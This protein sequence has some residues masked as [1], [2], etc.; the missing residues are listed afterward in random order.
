MAD[1]IDIEEPDYNSI[2]VSVKKILGIT[3]EYTHFDPELIMHINTVL[4]ILTQ[5][6]VG[7]SY[8]SITDDSATW[9][10]FFGESTDLELIKSYV[11]MKVR[12]LFDPPQS[13]IISSVYEKTISE[14]EWRISVTVDPGNTGEE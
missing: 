12:M 6:G 7:E 14:L 2:L 3:A 11:G 13:S 5:I 1:I 4:G 9:S 8:F 10:D